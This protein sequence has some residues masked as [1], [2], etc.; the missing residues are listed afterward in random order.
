MYRLC[1]FHTE[2][3]VQHLGKPLNRM[4]CGSSAPSRGTGLGQVVEEIWGLVGSKQASRI[5]WLSWDLY[6]CPGRLAVAAYL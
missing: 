2:V 3:M 4:L 1:I 6:L 5:E